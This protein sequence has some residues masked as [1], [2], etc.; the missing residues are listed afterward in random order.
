MLRSR[1]K[2]KVLVALCTKENE[3]KVNCVLFKIII[4]LPSSWLTVYAG[5]MIRLYLKVT[6]SSSF[7]GEGGAKCA[8]NCAPLCARGRT[9][10]VAIVIEWASS[11][12]NGRR[13]LWWLLNVS[14]WENR[15]IRESFP[16]LLTS[17]FTPECLNLLDLSTVALYEVSSLYMIFVQIS[18]TASFHFAARLPRISGLILFKCSCQILEKIAKRYTWQILE[19]F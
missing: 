7:T 14:I 1:R 11:T 3:R 19:S 17:I 5:H 16:D 9:R 6:K 8:R 4:F 13:S 18:V 2:R 10:A 12:Q 15:N